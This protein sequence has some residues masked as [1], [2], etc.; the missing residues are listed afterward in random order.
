[1]MEQFARTALLIGREGVQRLQAARVAVFGI[2]GVGGHAT[3]ALVRS[4][5]G[6]VDLFDDD[7]VCLSNLNRQ[8][9]A[10]HDAIGRPKVEVMAERLK[11]INPEARVN[12]HQMFYMPERAEEV[13]FSAFDYILDCID[14]VTAKLDLIVR[15][16]AL[17]VPIISAMGAGN[18]LDPTQLRV[19]DIYE[20]QSCPLARVMRHEL[21]K[22]GI[23][24][25]K[26]VYSTEPALS[27]RADEAAP[28]AE[29]SPRRAT[30]GSIAFVPSAMGLIMASVVVRD[31]LNG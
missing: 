24:A 23:P 7:T 22:R 21:R 3:E 29:P 11:S 4:G 8:L 9:I 20:T 31:L 18:R 2:G 12:A 30:P 19:G 28:N 6:T 25:L 27:P 10:T 16:N 14:T 17:G 13:D 15:A 5:I 1:M 26:V